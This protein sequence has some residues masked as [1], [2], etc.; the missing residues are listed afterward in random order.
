MPMR[1]LSM[2]AAF[3]LIAALAF[4]G[5]SPNP[6]WFPSLMAFEHYDSGRTHLFEQARFGGSFG[7]RNQVNVRVAHAIYPSGYNMVYLNPDEIFLYGG[8]Y[9]NIK[10]S[11]GAFVA[12]VD[13]VTLQPIWYTQLVNT[14]VNGEWDYPGVVSILD[15]GFLYLIF[16][17]RLAKLDPQDGTLVGSV[18]LPTIEQVPP[19]NTS[20]NGFDGLPDGTLIAKTVYR[21]AGGRKQGQ[22]AHFQCQNAGF[23]WIH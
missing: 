12:K 1:V 16:G 11:T 21:V 15:D 17:Y 2:I 9:G 23:N 22:D 3:S 8:G 6:P 4:A 14:A 19:E 18:E 10:N 5:Q 20:Y 13:P 7:G